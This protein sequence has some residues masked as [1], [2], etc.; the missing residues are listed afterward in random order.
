MG[1]KKHIP[2]FITLLNL[3]CGCIAV[4]CAVSSDFFLAALFV[5]AGI[6][7]DFMDGLT[8]RLLN[9]KSALGLQ[10]DSLADMITSGVVPGVVMFK[11]LTMSLGGDKTIFVEA[12]WDQTNYWHG[13]QVPLLAFL[14]FLITLSSAY[15]LAKFNLDED[16]Q[17][18]FKGLPTPANTILI[19]SLPL[20]LEFQG[21]TLYHKIILNPWFLIG[22]TLL[23]SYLLNSRIKLFALKF[24]DWSFKSNGVRYLFIACTL[25]LIV[26]FK[27]VAIPIIVL[28][29]ILLSLLTKSSIK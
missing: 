19:I 1:I 15:R 29:Y 24:S 3:L 18:Y 5:F 2:N 23:S 6:F 16:Q 25:I 9:V 11:L 12:S 7:F 20:I 4:L 26:L 13:L 21:S 27:F 22:L 10:L 28:F 8:A 17:S 14:G